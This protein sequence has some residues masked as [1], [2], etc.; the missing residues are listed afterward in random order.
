MRRRESQDKEQGGERERVEVQPTASHIFRQ[1]A[2]TRKQITNLGTPLRDASTSSGESCEGDCEVSSV[3]RPKRKFERDPS[4][5]FLRSGSEECETRRSLNLSSPPVIAAGAAKRAKTGR[6]AEAGR[7]L[8]EQPLGSLCQGELELVMSFLPVESLAAL[9]CTCKYFAE[10]GVTEEVAKRKVLRSRDWVGLEPNRVRGE[11][12]MSLLHYL[13]ASDKAR[14]SESLIGLGSYHTALVDQASSSV[15]T[16]GRG[17]HG[18]LG[19]GQY[20][21]ACTVQRIDLDQGE[22]DSELSSKALQV[23]CGSSHNAVITASGSMYSWGLASSGELGHGGW[24]PIDLNV[25]K[26]L[27]CLHKV[28]ITSVSCGSNHTVATS[29]CGGL[30]TCGRG[31]NG[32]LGHGQLH[33]EG[34]MKRVEALARHRVVKA[35]AGGTH[36]MC[37]SSNGMVFSWGNNICGQ[38]GHHTKQNEESN[39]FKSVAIP[40]EVVALRPKRGSKDPDRMVSLSCGLKH[41]LAVS[42]SGALYVWGDNAQGCLGLGDNLKRQ[43][44]TRVRLGESGETMRCV[45]ACAG[46]SHTAVLMY[47]SKTCTTSLFTTGY[48]NYGQLGHNDRNSRFFFTPVEYFQKLRRGNV[49]VESITLG[50]SSSAAVLSDKSIYLWGRGELGQLGTNDWRSWFAPRRIV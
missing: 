26:V 2:N 40:Q 46:G 4:F 39:L 11:T 45:H 12:W 35:A 29:S 19:N 44:P 14:K 20:E 27:S 13:T 30:W 6:K 16:C 7:G 42:A 8:P 33:D 17:F 28:R 1:C 38:L 41:S 9:N 3:L 43:M 36:S 50:D 25:P 47:N 15:Y 32:Q 18:Q 24:T 5:S 34:P 37:L 23:A 31:R 21:N 48:N 49:S 10:T 22:E